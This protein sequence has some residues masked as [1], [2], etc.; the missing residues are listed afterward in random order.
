MKKKILIISGVVI[1]LIGILIGLYIYLLTPIG[2]NETV[3]FTVHKGESKTEIISNLKEANLIKSKYATIIYLVITNQKNMQAGTY[4]FKRNM[5]AS[6]IVTA[7]NN[8]DI[9]GIKKEEVSVLLVEGVTLKKYLKQI[10]DVTNLDY[11]ESLKKVNDTTFLK[12]LIKDYWFLTEEILDP[13]I[14]YAL[15]GYLFPETYNFY[16]NTSLEEVIRKML[17]ETSKRLEPLKEEIESSKYSVHELLTIA[18]IAEKEANSNEDRE[19]VSQVIYKRLNIGMSLGMD[20]T[21]YYGVGKDMKEDTLT[22]LDLLDKNPY[23]TRVTT[24]IGLPVGPICN[25][26]L[27]SIKAALNPSDTDYLYFVADILTGKVYF[28]KDK[29]G[30]DELKELYI[31]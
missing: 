31:K 4:E 3:E 8:G 25:P 12:S 11:E 30:F 28:A 2:K 18:S 29:A 23:N 21:S 26:S 6:E 1:G 22:T 9:K 10:S 27:S 24:F 7:L 16:K 13:D 14:Y 15:E 5:S 20:V 19:M 17:N